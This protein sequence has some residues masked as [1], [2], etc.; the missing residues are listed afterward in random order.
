M[1]AKLLQSWLT[2]CDPMDCSLSGSSIYGILQARILEWVVIPFSIFLNWGLN[3][4]LLYWQADSLPL[5]HQGS[6]RC[7]LGAR[8]KDFNSTHS[9]GSKGTAHPWG[10]VWWQLL[11]SECDTQGIGWLDVGWTT[12]SLCIRDISVLSCHSVHKYYLSTYYVPGRECFS[13]P[14]P[15]TGNEFAGLGWP[16]DTCYCV[17][18]KPHP[19]EFWELRALEQN[20]GD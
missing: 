16:P 8:K 4:N 1:H 3:L 17:S 6:P 12:V 18:A 11:E 2:L 10:H 5:S 20:K 7:A 19:E 13:P 14:Q 9:Q 15:Q